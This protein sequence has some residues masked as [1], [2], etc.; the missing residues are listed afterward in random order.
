MLPVRSRILESARLNSDTASCLH[1]LSDKASGTINSGNVC[2][3]AYAIPSCR[4]KRLSNLDWRS[5]CQFVLLLDIYPGCVVS[6]S[7]KVSTMLL[8]ISQINCVTVQTATYH[9]SSERRYVLEILPYR[10]FMWGMGSG[11]AGN[12]HGNNGYILILRCW[13]WEWLWY[14]W[15]FAHRLHPSWP[16]KTLALRLGH[17][18]RLRGIL[19]MRSLMSLD[20]VAMGTCSNPH[21][22]RM[23]VY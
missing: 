19:L 2:E 5:Y 12:N 9:R 14:A 6:D 18:F 17:L 22:S 7:G 23:I 16:M 20:N 11:S 10:L 13:Y 21:T 3:C 8:W 4:Y 15:G 1:M